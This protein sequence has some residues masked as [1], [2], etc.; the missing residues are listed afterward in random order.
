MGIEAKGFSGQTDHRMRWASKQVFF[1]GE[2]GPETHN[3][4]GQR[5][6]GFFR[7]KSGQKHITEMD[8]E[9]MLLLFFGGKVVRNT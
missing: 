8:S 5:G 3:G 9:A 7:G 6:N 2:S 1:L 4:D